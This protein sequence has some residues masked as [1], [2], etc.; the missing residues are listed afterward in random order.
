MCELH[1]V[2]TRRE[3]ALMDSTNVKRKLQVL[4]HLGI[5]KCHNTTKHDTS[6]RSLRCFPCKCLYLCLLVSLPR[7]VVVSPRGKHD[8]WRIFVSSACLVCEEHTQKLEAGKGHNTKQKMQP[9][10]TLHRYRPCHIFPGRVLWFVIVWSPTE[11]PQHKNLNR[12]NVITRCNQW[13][14]P[15]AMVH[16]MFFLQE[17]HCSLGLSRFVVHHSASDLLYCWK[18]KHFMSAC[19][20]AENT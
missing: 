20:N 15:I 17:G 10:T 7:V 16:A 13:Q 3:M 1:D 14:H 11:T 2:N 8:P 4:W 5:P 19:Q 6:A 9:M 12:T 18:K